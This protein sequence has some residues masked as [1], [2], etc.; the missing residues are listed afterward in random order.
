LADVE[1]ESFAQGEIARLEELRLVALEERIDARLSAGEHALVVA[2]LEQLAADHP[3]RERLVGQL[4]LALYRSARQAEALEIYT[5]NRQ[6]LDAELG[7]EPS[8][9]LRHLQEAILR[10]DPALDARTD[11]PIR[12]GQDEVLLPL[13]GIFTRRHPCR[14]PP[15]RPAGRCDRRSRSRRSCD[16]RLAR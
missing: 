9:Q 7:L 1:F 12:S 4:M 8:S 11:A 10:Q 15:R 5:Q 2:E 13:R 16:V 6:R 14:R 3:L